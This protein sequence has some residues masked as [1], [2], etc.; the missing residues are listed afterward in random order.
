MTDQEY[1]ARLAKLYNCSY[2]AAAMFVK[3]NKDED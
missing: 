1:I 3:G 2:R